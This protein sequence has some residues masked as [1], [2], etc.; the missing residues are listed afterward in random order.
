MKGDFS[1][2]TY[3]ASSQYSRVMMQ[4]GRV[5]IDA[6]WN[7]QTAILLGY[8]RA[9]TRDLFGAHAGPATECGFQIVTTVS[10]AAATAAEQAKLDAAMKENG[11][12]LR[13]DDMLVLPG[14][15]YVGGLPVEAGAP[16]LF[17]KQS[18]F[19]FGDGPAESLRQRHWLAYLD[20]WEDYVSSDQDP[21]MREVALGGVD[22]CGRAQIRWRVRLLF[23]PEGAGDLDLRAPTGS[24]RISVRAN[25][26]E[27][28]DSLCAIA[29]DARYRG[30]ENQLYRVE[31]QTG[32]AAD[33]ATF[34]WSRDNG[35]ITF[36]VISGKGKS[37]SLGHLGRDEAT[38]LVE[39][40][41]VELVDDYITGA[42]QLAQVTA[43]WRDDLRVDLAFPGTNAL[44]S[45]W[46]DGA[47]ARHALLR[48]WDHRGDV[49][50][51]GGAI[52]IVPNQEI[53]LEDGVK[54]TFEPGG[55][56][57][58]GDYWTIPA[59]VATGD[60]EWPGTPDHP[61]YL[62]PMGP[63]HYYAPLAL[64]G[65]DA[66]KVELSDLRC[67]IARLPCVVEKRAAVPK[68]AVDVKATDAVA[69][70]VAPAVAVKAAEP[71]AAT[72]PVIE[73]KAEATRPVV[74]VKAAEEARP[75]LDVKAVEATR[76]AIDV[77]AAE[78]VRPV[79]DVK[80][81]EVL[82]PVLRATDPPKPI[83]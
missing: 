27:N 61:E 67:R 68:A 29:P 36:P 42:G 26:T 70:A 9:L 20:V 18:G 8:M 2:D 6:D 1:R 83:A 15:Y 52:A 63:K 21:Y 69:P 60:V 4:Q 77:K 47:R 30:A 32:G 37:V 3:R 10:R 44:A 46:A 45:D 48:R 5:Q 13:D 24:G 64:F 72:R 12:E 80:A 66:G 22:T 23:D 59:R 49:K 19:P 81:E 25:P 79:L 34:K 16:F 35:A 78:A 62:L 28:A 82:K 76:P 7:E 39:G 38:T 55:I 71:V 74:E 33:G 73:V 56:Y 11:I 17:T 75:V 50:T 57:R 65:P 54:V 14:R 41:W 58:P 31:M 40:D 53:E 43:V 51:A